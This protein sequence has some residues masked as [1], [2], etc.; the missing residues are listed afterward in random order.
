MATVPSLDGRR[1]GPEGSTPYVDSAP[2]KQ[3]AGA[4]LQDMGRAVTSAGQDASA[5]FIDHLREI[6]ALRVDEATIK[7][8]EIQDHL[9]FDPTNGYST[10]KGKDALERPDGKSLVEEYGSAYDKEL[11]SIADGLGNDAQRRAFQRTAAALGA[12][13]RGNLERHALNETN[14]YGKSVLVGKIGVLQRDMALA[15]SDPAR[16]ERSAATIKQSVGQLAKYA[17]WS[18]DEIKLK[19]QAALSEAYTSALNS[20]LD[21]NDIASASAYFDLHKADMTAE[22]IFGVTKVLRAKEQANLV[23]EV[24]NDY[25]GPVVGGSSPQNFIP[26]VASVA[27]VSG[28]FGEQRPDHKHAGEDYP[29]A[30]GSPVVASADGKVKFVGN[31]GSYGNLVIVEHPDGYETRYAH[32]EGFGNIKPGDVIRQG[33]VVGKVGSTGNSTGPHLH[34]EVRRNGAAVDPTGAYK[35]SR[36]GGISLEEAIL[37]VRN[38]PRVA[39]NPE[40]LAQAEQGVRSIYSAH[41]ESVREIENQAVDK[42]YEALLRNGGYVNKLPASV[43]ASIPGSSLPSLISFGMAL[44][45]GEEGDDIGAWATAKDDIANGN[46]KNLSQILNLQGKVSKAHLNDLVG[47]FAAATGPGAKDANRID[48]IKTAQE[49]FRYITQEL[50]S[51]GVDLNPG[52]NADTEDFNRAAKFKGRYYQQVERAIKWKGEELT[53][54]ELRQIGLGLIAE[55]ALTDDGGWFGRTRTLRGYELGGDVRLPYNAIPK[56]TR[57][58]IATGLRARGVTP[59]E[60]R[61]RDEYY[62]Y[63]GSK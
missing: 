52:K 21:S 30:P 8:K 16:T 43:R 2:V 4:Q 9:T 59:T 23:N 44:Q 60:A 26:P 27:R 57:D 29:A 56:E 47:D 10:L 63:G 15:Y 41:K 53:G 32:L 13:F 20:M 54:E 14:E 51:A 46:I 37:R 3:V 33:V 55:S 61:V 1:V 50:K 24:V 28:R 62:K 35:V 38:D 39:G 31:Q 49:G 19:E 22:H 36:T 5:I 18:A 42:A 6:N 7:A 40:A 11:Q 45:S 25:A 17:G 58:I 12:G 48:Y 34:F